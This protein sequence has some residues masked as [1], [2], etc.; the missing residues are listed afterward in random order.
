MKFWLDDSLNMTVTTVQTLQ[1]SVESNTHPF[2]PAP[3]DWPRRASLRRM[4][5]L[6]FPMQAKYRYRVHVQYRQL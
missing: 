1:N 3:D 4:H 5:L 6:V 2:G